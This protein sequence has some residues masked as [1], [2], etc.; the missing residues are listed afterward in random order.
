M[1]ETPF[2]PL[3]FFRGAHRQTFAGWIGKGPVAPAEAEILKVPLGE[4]DSTTLHYYEPPGLALEAPTLVLLHGLEGDATRPYMIRTAL[5]AAARGFRAARMNMRWCGDA[6]GLSKKFY[7]STQSGDVAK[8][9][10]FLSRR[11][12]A[13]P[14]AALGFSLGGNTILKMAAER[15]FPVVAVAAVCPPV[16]LEAASLKIVRPHNRFY[17][18]Y[19]VRSMVDRGNRFLT[20]N[21]VEL[22]ATLDYRM[23]IMEFDTRF[24]VPLGGF[25]SLDDYYTKGSSI[26]RLP[27][28]QCPTLILCAQDDP[29]IPFESFEGIDGRV[30]VLATRT[31][32]H[33]GFVGRR[34]PRDPD[35]Y[36]AENRLLDFLVERL[37]EGS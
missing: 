19:L 35:R 22:E 34:D 30:R 33:L 2:A 8:V 9:C 11:Y 37:E 18:R 24:T 26:D 13:S 25:E 1:N 32:G 29:L 15:L 6:E 3:P 5:K 10:E 4:G 27:D 7:N 21:K 31:G 28:I 14:I 16:D 23:T 36:W 17:H 12:P 20:G